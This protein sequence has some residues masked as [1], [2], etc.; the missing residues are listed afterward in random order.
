[1]VDRHYVWEVLA[2]RLLHPSKLA[3]V[4]ALLEQSQPLSLTQLAEAAGIPVEH[5]RY[6]C[7]SMERAG[8][9]ED[10]SVAPRPD[11]EGEGEGEGDEPSYFFAKPPQ[12]SSSPSP[13]A[14]ER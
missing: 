10:I 12:A 14:T 2:P 5:A 3:I 13:Q 8:V 7:R 11:R 6:Q 9:L 4:Q 1:V